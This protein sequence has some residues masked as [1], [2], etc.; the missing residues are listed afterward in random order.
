MTE[1][2]SH[3]LQFLREQGV[4][5]DEDGS[6]ASSPATPGQ[7]FIAPLSHL[8]VIAVSGADGARFLHG[9]LSNDIEHLPAG[10][11]RLAAYC[12]PKGRMLA[13]MLAWRDG[14]TVRLQL[15]REILAAIQ[16]RLQMFVLRSKVK[17]EDVSASVVC[18]GFAGDA[19]ATLATIVDGKLPGE[20]YGSAEFSAG[21]VIRMPDSG[22]I[23][24]YQ[25]ITDPERASAAGQL[26][27][28]QLAPASAWR[29]SEIVAGVPMI[30]QTTQEKFVP[31]MINF[32]L[33]GGVNFRKGCYPGQEIVARSQYLGKLKRR[34]LPAEIDT[35]DVA[36]GTEVYASTDPDQPSGQIVNAEPHADGGSQCLVELKIAVLDQQATL[37][38]GS[39]NGPQLR[40]LPSPYSLTE[41]V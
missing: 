39:A 34:M 41:P 25:W 23:A 31:Q 15:P 27:T 29:R 16:K 17:L 37:H 28:P 8:G 12:T 33:L 5:P 26:M 24:R 6:A 40:I 2:T 38:L 36:A 21:T 13:S 9:Q 35:P 30:V 4:G 14:D 10:Q 3:W 7:H 22:S 18:L 19:A 20:V 32:E 1:S 11:A